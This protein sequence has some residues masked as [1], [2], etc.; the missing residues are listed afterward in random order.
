MHHSRGHCSEPLPQLELAG[1]DL[2]DPSKHHH[3]GQCRQTPSLDDLENENDQAGCRTADEQWRT[4]EKSDDDSSDHARN[5]PAFGGNI[6]RDCDANAQRN[7]DQEDYKG[8]Q[9]VGN[10]RFTASRWR[11]SATSH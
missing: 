11:Q 5:E 2:P 1:N 3:W 9:D 7:C 8:R 10:N 6:A 4:R